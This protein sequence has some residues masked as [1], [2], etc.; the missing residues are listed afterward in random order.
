MPFKRAPLSMLS[1]G[2]HIPKN[3][4][5]AATSGAHSV[6]A[7]FEDACPA[8]HRGD[9]VRSIFAEAARSWNYEVPLGVRINGFDTNLQQGDVDTILL[10]IE[11]VTF[12]V[13]P[14]CTSGRDVK[15]VKGWLTSSPH[16]PALIAIVEHPSAFCRQ[17]LDDIAQEIALWEGG[18]GLLFGTLDYCSARGIPGW[19]DDEELRNR[20][21]DI[22]RSRKD[23]VVDAA[24]AHGILAIDGV[25][26][27]LAK[28]D[29]TPERIAAVTE[30]LHATTQ[31]SA[32][33][34]FDLRL[35][36]H[37]SQIEVAHKYYGPQPDAVRTAFRRLKLWVDHGGGVLADPLK[38][39]MIDGASIRGIRGYL[40][41][42]EFGLANGSIG[43]PSFVELGC[44]LDELITDAR[45]ILG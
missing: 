35:L 3:Y 27:T 34:G 44:K 1:F 26:L 16:K 11:H 10:V 29:A 15:R 37:P 12:I 25:H 8:D 42:A 28:R 31:G 41:V 40:A 38:G 17:N 22:L 21:N 2:G 33:I 24:R 39:D 9:P 13:I 6:M 5:R 45:R 19:Q 14:K 23:A 20:E 4:E 32:T 18:G 36:I 30:G 7:D 43:L